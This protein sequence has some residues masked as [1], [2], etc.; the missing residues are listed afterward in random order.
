MFS[1]T[2]RPYSDQFDVA[3]VS[4][5]ITAGE[6]TP[7]RA[8]QAYAATAGRPYARSSFEQLWRNHARRAGAVEHC[9]AP[10]SPPATDAELY[11]QSEAYWAEHV[12]PK[13]SRVLTLTSDNIALR[14]KGGGLQIT[15]PQMSGPRHLYFAPSARKPNAIVLS[16]WGGVVT[17]EALR[18]CDDYKVALVVLDWTHGLMSVTSPNPKAN[19]TLVRT[20]SKSLRD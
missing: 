12:A 17:I 13:S 3:A 20:P 2:G 7:L 1:R 6:T 9:Q 14:V 16:G 11:V 4:A 8:Y 15:D 10:A 19:A 18:F 5:A